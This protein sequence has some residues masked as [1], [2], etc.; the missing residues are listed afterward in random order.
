MYTSDPTEHHVT[1]DAQACILVVDDRHEI[2][3]FI[4]EILLD[5]GYTV[6]TAHDAE[7]T[8]E[9]ITTARPDLLLLDVL[10]PQISG[11]DVLHQLHRQYPDL[12]IILMSASRLDETLLIEAGATAF[13]AKP[14]DMYDLLQLIET[15]LSA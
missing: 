1:D 13:L 8:V 9:I 4:S 5:E 7:Q 12:P 10:M 2:T 3:D 6:V 15:H 11:L 14:F